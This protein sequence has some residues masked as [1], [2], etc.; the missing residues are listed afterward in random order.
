M[1]SAKAEASVIS[2]RLDGFDRRIGRIMARRGLVSTYTCKKYRVHSS[3]SNEAVIPKLFAR[4]FNKQAP[5][6]SVVSDLTY[7]RF[8]TRWAHVCILL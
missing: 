4:D 2:E 7:A 1:L 3:K 6:A 5:G 8:G